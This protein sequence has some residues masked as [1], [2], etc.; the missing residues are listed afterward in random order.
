MLAVF[1]ALLDVTIVNVAFPDIEADFE[2]ASLSDLSWILNAYNVVFAALLIPAGRLADRIGRRRLFY[3]GLYVFLLGSL[4]CGLA[5]DAPT[6][7]A[8]RVLQAAGAAALIPTSL[9]LLLPEFAPEKR[10]TAVSLWAAAGAVAAA[11]G[12]SLGGVLVD[13]GGWRWA[14]YV[15]LVIALGVLPGRRLLVERRDP[16]AGAVAD[17]LGGSMLAGSVGLLALGIVKAPD[18]GWGDSRVLGCWLASALLLA[19]LLLRSRRHPSPVLEPELLRIKSFATASIATLVYAAGFYALLLCNV[20]FLN[21]VWGYSVLE[22]GFGVTPGP[23]AAVVGAALAGRIVEHR[24]P[25]G[26]VVVAALM[27]GAAFLMYRSLPGATPDYL[28]TW[29]PCQIVSGAGAGMVFAAL[30]TATVMDLPANRIATGTALASCLRQIG[31][32]L[33]IAGLVAVLGTPSPEEALGVFDDAYTLMAVCAAA[34]AVV[35]LRLPALKPETIGDAAPLRDR[36]V[37]RAVPGLQ[38]IEVELHGSRVVYRTAGSGPPIILIHGLLDSGS[39]WR[40]VAPVLAL[41]HRVIVPDLLGHGDTDGPARADYSIGSH[42]MLVRDLMNEL[43]IERAT[44]VGHSLGAGVALALAYMAPER[45][46]RLAIISAGG[47]GRDLAPILR[48]ATVPGMGVVLRAVG[49]RPVTAVLRAIAAALG[50]VGARRPSRSLIDVGRMLERLGDAGARGAFLESARAVIDVRGQKAS[51]TRLMPS[52]TMP[53]L[54]MWGTRDR[55]IPVRH[56]D[57]VTDVRPDAEVVL[58]EGVGHMPQ[59]AQPAFV[60]ERLSEWVDTT[61]PSPRGQFQLKPAPALT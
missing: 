28:A 15:N 7:I 56:A 25:R 16:Q 38:A 14:F 3:T 2:D 22:A 1:M 30:S 26:I 61:K 46:E 4:L 32:V 35:A 21:Q 10:A 20:L 43:G 57:L 9:G 17:A 12:P 33:G 37:P 29:L 39:T 45:V 31:A 11:A 19:A 49:S 47:I 52:F 42:A 41:R 44:V 24:G 48:M 27:S 8:A 59:L 13:A 5:P 50:A 34:A 60:A 18:W 53:L 6:L 55:V 51:A 36:H 23:L 58:L 40:K 54:V